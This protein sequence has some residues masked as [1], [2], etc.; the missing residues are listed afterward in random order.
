MTTS[1]LWTRASQLLEVSATEQVWSYDPVQWVQ[2]QFGATPDEWQTAALKALGDGKSVAIRSGHG[3]GKTAFLAWSVLWW[4]DTKT[5]CKIP[6]AAPTEHQLVDH[7]WPEMQTWLTRSRMDLDK[8]IVW[9]ATRVYAKGRDRT[10]FAVMR[11][12]G[13]DNKPE[14]LA[15]FHS[16]NL[17]FIV[18]EASGVADRNMTVVTGALTTEGAQLVMTGNPTR[19]TGYFANKFTGDKADRNW[20]RDSISS[21]NSIR[22]NS[23]W[24]KDVALEW[25]RES[26]EYRIR[27]LGLPPRGDSKGFMPPDLVEAAQNR[28]LEAFGPLVLGVDV[29]RYGRDASCIAVRRGMRVIKYKL[30]RKLGNPALVSRVIDMVLAES[31]SDEETVR[32]IVD[33]DGVGGGVT[34]LLKVAM[35]E[36]TLENRISVTGVTFGGAGNRFFTT[37]AGVWWARLR[38]MMQE[39]SID[40]PAGEDLYQQLTDRTSTVN[41]KGKTVLET[42]EHMRDRGVPSPDIAD[43]VCLT[44]ADQSQSAGFLEYW[45]SD[46]L[47]SQTDQKDPAKLF[48]R[49]ARSCKHF[50]GLSIPG[51]L[52]RTCNK[53]GVETDQ[54]GRWL[55]AETKSSSD[56]GIPGGPTL[57][58]VFR[59]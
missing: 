31:I 47:K 45:K 56:S 46:T 36:G 50:A 4:L 28:M 41:M 14:N 21:A 27:V 37:N 44:I 48:H 18:D 58:T 8:R 43:A 11:A 10:A 29:A 38:R 12:A 2:D 6:C 32:I 59:G 42:K 53:C 13:P 24:A 39:G 5:Y 25:G 40:I 7:L 30:Y 35:R 51:V 3:V 16:D 54:E 20:H 22:V 57:T 23:D 55:D 34:D 19:A 17:L 49:K 33:D 52:V 26:D 9:T 15:G 1:A